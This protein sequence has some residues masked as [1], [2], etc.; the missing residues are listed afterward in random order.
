M[1][2]QNITSPTSSPTLVNLTSTLITAKPTC[3]PSLKLTLTCN[4]KEPTLE[5][6]LVAKHSKKSDR[7]KKRVQTSAAKAIL[8]PQ[9][10]SKVSTRIQTR[11]AKSAS[12]AVRSSQTVP[13]R[14][15]KLVLKLSFSA[16][17][18]PFPMLDVENGPLDDAQIRESARHLLALKSD[19]NIPMAA[20]I[21]FL[22]EQLVAIHEKRQ[23]IVD[24]DSRVK[25]KAR[26]ASSA[27]SSSNAKTP[28]DFVE[29]VPLTAA[30]FN[31]L[32]DEEIRVTGFGVHAPDENAKTEAPP[33][34]DVEV[35]SSQL[36]SAIPSKKSS[37]NVNNDFCSACLESGT[38]L[39][40]DKCPKSFHFSCLEPPIT[41]HSS[42]AQQWFCNE[43]QSTVLRD[44]RPGTPPFDAP[45]NERSSSEKKSS[46]QATAVNSAKPCELLPLGIIERIN[47]KNPKMFQL[48]SNFVKI[49]DSQQQSFCSFVAVT[50]SLKNISKSSTSSYNQSQ[51]SCNTKKRS[52]SFYSIESDAND[53]P[54]L[55]HICGKS[56]RHGP[57]LDCFYCP[58]SFHPDC[59][60]PPVPYLCQSEWMCPLH[61][62]H[63]ARFGDENRLRLSSSKSGYHLKR[64]KQ[65]YPLKI[66]SSGIKN[67]GN[68]DIL[69]ESPYSY[70]SGILPEC[71]IRMSLA[72]KLNKPFVSFPKALADEHSLIDF[73]QESMCKQSD[74]STSMLLSAAT[75]NNSDLASRFATYKSLV[76]ETE[77]LHVC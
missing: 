24:F 34:K 5:M 55:C 1:D 69:I 22:F 42:L 44:D 38:F 47:R 17:S 56:F 21:S 75:H 68:V 30:E 11:N 27:A 61:I 73:G 14:L 59:V 52:K 26:R 65:S 45:T 50:P 66:L 18:S 62:D 40:C 74:L 57:L 70:T 16:A 53:G 58:L 46:K 67:D 9:L 32:K 7:K 37:Q 43:C 71:D 31:K 35:P 76:C 10:P 4:E 13:Q 28:I 12:E 6:P 8:V 33:S 51:S 29:P 3:A 77:T 54:A 19:E 15:D 72:S 41:S 48:P 39:C 49:I 23:K 2:L 36:Q 60:D 64:H 63:C 20:R 25:I